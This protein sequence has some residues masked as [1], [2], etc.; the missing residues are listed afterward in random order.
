MS[1]CLL[2]HCVPGCISWYSWN[3]YI[4]IRSYNL[5]TNYYFF[6]S[7]LMLSISFSFLIALGKISSTVLKRNGHPC[8]T[9]DLSRKT[10]ML[11]LLNKMLAVDFSYQHFLCWGMFFSILNFLRVFIMKEFWI[12]CF[13]ACIEIIIGFFNI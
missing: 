6:H 13:S 2:T 1:K 11:S 4:Y 5:Q 3:V 12:R 8:L 9:P 10:F 7:D